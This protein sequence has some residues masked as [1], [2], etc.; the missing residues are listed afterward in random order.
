LSE[1]QFS[2]APIFHCT[3]FL[4]CFEDTWQF[5][6]EELETRLNN[7]SY[8]ANVTLTY[9]TLFKTMTAVTYLYVKLHQASYMFNQTNDGGRTVHMS[10]INVGWKTGRRNVEA[11]RDNLFGITG[12]Q[13][14]W[15]HRGTIDAIIL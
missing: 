4:R 2:T 14:N 6:V 7:P 13:V 10:G 3:K 11:C 9:V 1:K 8:F 5:E 12:E 15:Q